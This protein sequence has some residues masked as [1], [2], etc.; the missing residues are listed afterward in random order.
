M[1]IVHYIT[2]MFIAMQKVIKRPQIHSLSIE[3]IYFK[4]NYDAPSYQLYILSTALNNY[5]PFMAFKMHNQQKKRGL[6]TAL[7]KPSS[8]HPPD[9]STLH[10]LNPA[11]KYA[12]PRPCS[13]P[14]V[15]EF[16][17]YFPSSYFFLGFNLPGKTLRV[18]LIP[19]WKLLSLVCRINC[20]L[21]S[22]AYL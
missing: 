19:V 21:I 8:L 5:K 2:C 3:H 14:H 4:G 10:V 15:N 22:S 20:G 1:R 17:I 6:K 18:V 13:I 12:R 9:S 16:S 11:L 7:W